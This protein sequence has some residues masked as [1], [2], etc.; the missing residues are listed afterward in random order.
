MVYASPS[1]G[2][3]QLT[4]TTRVEAGEAGL[5]CFIADARV[6]SGSCTIA[7]RP[8]DVAFNGA[9]RSSDGFACIIV[10]RTPPEERITLHDTKCGRP[11]VLAGSSW[12]FSAKPLVGEFLVYTWVLWGQSEV[13]LTGSMM[14]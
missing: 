6:S 1:C 4:C 3:I 8:C 9:P 12:G 13:S 7:G 2:F 14:K 5:Q 10:V 11:M